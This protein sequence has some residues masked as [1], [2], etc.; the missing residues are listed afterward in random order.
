MTV[1]IPQGLLYFSYGT[2]WK[3]FFDNLGVKY[4]TSGETNKSILS[5]GTNLCV[6]EACL[7]VKVYHGHV[8]SL[9]KK[10]D[11]IFMPRIISVCKN[12][13]ICPKFCGLSEMIK[14]S[15][16]DLPELIDVNVNLYKNETA[17]K[18]SFIETGAK[19][20]FDRFTSIKAY[21]EAQHAQQKTDFDKRLQGRKNLNSKKTIVLLGHP[22]ILNDRYLNMDIISKIEKEG[23]NIITQEMLDDSIINDYAAVMPKRHFWTLGRRLLGG[24]LYYAGQKDVAGIIYLSSFACGIDSIM[25]DYLD[26]HIRRTENMPY[27][28]AV[29][30]EHSGE[31]GLV[32]RLEAFIDM[33]KQ[34]G[35]MPL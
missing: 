13:Y 20:G 12:E 23:Y 34:K 3:S 27:M 29:F 26:R 10:A 7:P 15:I 22:Y 28:K 4:V 25:E 11:I 5:S 19:L 24:G 35:E 9:A 6:D 31:A 21:N 18:K 16:K 17:L 32:T 2:L 14:N 8:K 33:I 30:D 1:G